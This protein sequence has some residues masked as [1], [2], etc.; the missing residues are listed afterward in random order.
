[1][2]LPGRLLLVSLLALAF[3]VPQAA[4]AQSRGTISGTEA[5]QI[6]KKLGLSP[7]YG[8]DRYGDPQIMFQMSGLF[9]RM[10]FFDCKQGRCGSIQ[11]ETALDL[12]N[13]TTVQV[14]NE[15]NKTYRYGRM[16]LDEEM[17]PYLQFDFE[18][19]ISH[20]EEYI[21]SQLDTFELLLEHL[22][23]AVEYY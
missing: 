3:L 4:F 21:T 1:M 8:R 17:D 16:Y 15:Y 18:L 11:L 23:E 5:L 19:P 13:G 6:L 7:E 20:V 14:M 10:N 2:R 9:C 12:A 22:T